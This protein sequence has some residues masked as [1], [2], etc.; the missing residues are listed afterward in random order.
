MLKVNLHGAETLECLVC[1]DSI[2]TN[3]LMHNYTDNLLSWQISQF[4]KYTQTVNVVFLNHNIGIFCISFKKEFLAQYFVVLHK[5]IVKN[6]VRI[7]TGSLQK[8]VESLSRPIVHWAPRWNTQSLIKI[9]GISCT[10]LATY[11]VIATKMIT[12]TNSMSK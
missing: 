10:W 3:K 11:T 8:F 1:Q 7:I 6:G 2:S 9:W 5:F 4:L 12:P